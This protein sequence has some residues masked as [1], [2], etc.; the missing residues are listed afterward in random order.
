MTE[1]ELETAGIESWEDSHPHCEECKQRGCPHG[2]CDMEGLVMLTDGLIFHPLCLVKA[3]ASDA[4]F[5][6][7]EYRMVR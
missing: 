2:C 4:A 6:N 1:G 7:V 3:Q 5:G